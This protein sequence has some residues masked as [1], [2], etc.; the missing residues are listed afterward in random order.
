MGVGVS[1]CVQTVVV[2]EIDGGLSYSLRKE[3]YLDLSESVRYKIKQ[4]QHLCLEDLK[5]FVRGKKNV[6]AQK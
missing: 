3:V 2:P 4:V 5:C 1:C 6:K